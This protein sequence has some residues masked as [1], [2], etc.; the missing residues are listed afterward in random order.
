MHQNLIAKSDS[1]IIPE[2]ITSF[3]KQNLCLNELAPIVKIEYQGKNLPFCF[4]T[5]IS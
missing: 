1:I 2:K 3:G 4:D 5:G